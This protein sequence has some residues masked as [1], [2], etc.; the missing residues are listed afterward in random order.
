[1]LYGPQV[2]RHPWEPQTLRSLGGLLG[3]QALLY[4]CCYHLG[5]LYGPQV[6]RCLGELTRAPGAALNGRSWS[7]LDLV[8]RVALGIQ[9]PS[10]LWLVTQRRCA[11][12]ES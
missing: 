5:E 4:P 9:V 3:H 12:W 7:D 11:T 8:R 1:M 6:L 10:A 2:L